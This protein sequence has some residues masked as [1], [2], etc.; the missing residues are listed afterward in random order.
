MRCGDQCCTCECVAMLSGSHLPYNYYNDYFYCCYESSDYV[1]CLW[2]VPKAACRVTSCNEQCEYIYTT[3]TF[4]Y[5]TKV[6]VQSH[7]E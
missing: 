3:V 5:C 2:K 6:A 7:L 4:L 1:R